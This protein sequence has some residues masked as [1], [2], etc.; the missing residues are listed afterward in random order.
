MGKVDIKE[1]EK[2]HS[3]VD[4]LPGACIKTFTSKNELRSPKIIL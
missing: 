3:L 1:T 4:E 2:G